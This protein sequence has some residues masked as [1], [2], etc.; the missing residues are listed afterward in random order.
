MIAETPPL[1]EI[2]KE[3]LHLLYRELGLVNG[4]R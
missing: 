2:T 4:I 3:M 1:T